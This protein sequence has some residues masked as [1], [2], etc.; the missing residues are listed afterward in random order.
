MDDVQLTKDEQDRKQFDATDLVNKDPTKVYRWANKKDVNVARHKFNGYSVVDST[1]D[2]VRS[3]LDDGTKMKK[4]T[5]TSTMIEV[6]DMVLMSIPKEL[7]ERNLAR[8]AERIKRQTR[9]VSAAAMQ[10]I[11]KSAK[12]KV[13]FEEHKDNPAMK[14]MS[15]TAYEK[16]QEEKRHEEARN[17]R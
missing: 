14:G 5:D 15:I 2:K 17:R 9:G 12:G 8:R 16:L 1:S 3:V 7:Y 13:S 11:D 4:G 6:S 10:Q